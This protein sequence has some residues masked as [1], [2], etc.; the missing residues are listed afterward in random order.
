M[1]GDQL[2]ADFAQIVTALEAEEIHPALMRKVNRF[3]A[4][5]VQLLT[6]EEVIGVA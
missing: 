4:Q 5:L 6:E 2:V 3:Q 1:T